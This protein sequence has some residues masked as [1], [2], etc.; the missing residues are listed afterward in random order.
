MGKPELLSGGEWLM[1]GVGADEVTKLVPEEGI[2]LRYEFDVEEPGSRRFWARVGWFQARA[3]FQWRIDEGPWSEG[4]FKPGETYDD[5]ADRRAAENVF[6]LPAATGQ[7]RAGVELSGA[8][9]V[10]RYDDPNMDVDTYKPVAK[11]P[12]PADYPLRWMAFE[13][14]GNPW[15]KPPLVFGHRLI[16]RTRVR[17]P[18][19]HAGRGFQLH[20][21]G[22]N[23][24]MSVFVNG[25]IAGTHRGVWVPWDLDVTKHVRPGK[26]NEI[27]VA[28]KGTYYAQDPKGLGNKNTLMAMRARPRLYNRRIRETVGGKEAARRRNHSAELHGETAEGPRG[29]R[30]RARSLG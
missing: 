14:P 5:E 18:D 25:Q 20:F 19:D 30:G 7:Q 9:Q 22:T 10:A 4:P 27:A 3:A 13:V 24:I 16:Y 29:V 12:A 6:V 11:L 1:R 8:W 2:R 17:V 26:T 28:V 21:S 15:A 23:W